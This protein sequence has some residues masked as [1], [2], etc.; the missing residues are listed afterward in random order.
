MTEP[1]DGYPI[2]TDWL[3]NLRDIAFT[4]FESHR[5]ATEVRPLP[6]QELGKRLG[7]L[8]IT[9]SKGWGRISCVWFCLLGFYLEKRDFTEKELEDLKRPDWVHSS[10][11]VDQLIA[12]QMVSRRPFESL[13]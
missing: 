11:K 13:C 12:G 6:G 2:Y 3:N 9:P 7:A 4:G 8:G 5:E 10:T 1:V